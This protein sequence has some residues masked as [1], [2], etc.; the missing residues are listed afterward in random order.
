MR[1]LFAH[2]KRWFAK[3]VSK[4]ILVLFTIPEIIKTKI[5]KLK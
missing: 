1:I 5:N 2:L 3:G 4:K